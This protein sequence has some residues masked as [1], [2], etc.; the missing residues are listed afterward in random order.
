MK[1]LIIKCVRMVFLLIKANKK[2]KEMESALEKE[3]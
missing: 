3:K 2:I 1:N